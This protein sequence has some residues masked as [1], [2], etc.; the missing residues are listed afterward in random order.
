MK[1]LLQNPFA[2]KATIGQFVGILPAG[3]G[4]KF[5]TCSMH[6]YAHAL[7]S[8]RINLTFDVCLFTQLH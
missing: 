6:M 4:V 1:V 5:G 8:S 2:Q 7:T 3:R